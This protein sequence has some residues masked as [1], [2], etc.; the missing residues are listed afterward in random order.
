MPITRSGSSQPDPAS[1]LGDNREEAE[2]PLEYFPET[3]KLAAG[4]QFSHRVPKSGMVTPSCCEYLEGI[5]S[6]VAKLHNS[7]LV[8]TIEA[9]ELE[10]ELKRLELRERQLALRKRQ[11]KISGHMGEAEGVAM[12]TPSNVD[13]ATHAQL[14]THELPEVEPR[15]KP[16]KKVRLPELEL[17]KF[18]GEPS[19]LWR[20]LRTFKIDVAEHLS[21]DKER[22]SYLIHCCTG[23]AREAIEDCKLLLGVSGYAR[24]LKI[25]EMQFGC[26]DDVAEGLLEELVH[27]NRLKAG[28]VVGLRKLLRQATNCEISL[29]ELGYQASLNCS[30]IIKSVVR[31]LPEHLQ[32]KWA[33]QV[34][35]KRI[36]GVDL[37][38]RDLVAFL[39]RGLS[40]ST[41]CHG[42][43]SKETPSQSGH[44]NVLV[45]GTRSR[46]NSVVT[47]EQIGCPICQVKHRLE[48][49]R[50]FQDMIHE[51]RLSLLRRERR[52][53]KCLQPGHVAS[54][55]YT[56]VHCEEVGCGRRH[57]T[58]LHF[59]RTKS[60]SASI[61]VNSTKTA[62]SSYM[63]FVPVRIVGPTGIMETYAFLDSGSDTTL[64]SS[65][66]ATKVGISGP[67]TSIAISS[68]QGTTIKRSN[69]VKFLIRPLQ[70]E[71][72][73]RID[74]AYVVERLPVAR[75]SVPSEETVCQWPHLKSVR[76]SRIRNDKVGVLLGTN[77]PEVHWVQKQTIGTKTQ[78]YASLTVLGWVLFGPSSES[79]DRP[80]AVNCIETDDSIRSCV[81]KMFELDFADTRDDER[82]NLSVEDAKVL[83]LVRGSSKLYEGH[84]QLPLP[85]RFDWRKLPENRVLA[86][87]RLRYLMFRLQ[88]DSELSGQYD[89]IIR[90]YE[91]KGYISQL[92]SS[93]RQELR[94]LPHHPVINPRKPGKVRIVFDFAA[95]FKGMSIN[96]CLY[97]GP[98]LTNEL[99]SVLLR[100]RLGKIALAADIEE[101]F[102]Q[103]RLRLE[104]KPPLCFL[105]YPNGQL[106]ESP[107]VYQLNV[108]PFGATSSPFIA[109][110]AL[111]Q[112]VEDNREHFDEY[113]ASV[114]EENFYVDDCLTSVDTITTAI[115]LVEQLRC[116]LSRGGFRLH[117]WVSNSNEVMN[118]IPASERAEDLVNVCPS[119]STMQKTLG[120]YW[121]VQRDCFRFKVSLPS[122]PATR[123]GIL[124][125]SASL[126]DP[127]GFVAPVLLQPKR[128]LQNMCRLGCGWDEE[129]DTQVEAAWTKWLHDVR[130]VENLRIPRCINP[131]PSPTTQA[132]LHLFSD[133][134]EIG[135]GAVAYLRH[136]TEGSTAHVSFLMG[137]SRVAPLKAITIPR[138]ELQAA[139]LSVKLWS[140]VRRSLKI[141]V[142]RARFWTDSTI[143]LHY[144][145]NTRSRFKTFVANRI[146]VILKNTYPEQWG[147][148]HTDEN[149]ADLAS[150][151][152][153]REVI[154]NLERWLH[155]P[156]FL[157]Q[158]EGSWPRRFGESLKCDFSQLEIKKESTV[159]GITTSFDAVDV[160]ISYY[161]SWSKLLR[162]VAWLL[163]FK[164]YLRWNM[165]K[166]P[167]LAPAAGQLSCQ[168]LDSAELSVLRYVQS[169]S[170]GMT[171]PKASE[172]DTCKS[173]NVDKNCSVRK[174]SPVLVKGLICVGGRLNQSNISD[175]AKNPVILPSNHA[176]TECI[177]NYYHRT[178][179]HAGMTH[180]LATLRQKYWIIRGAATVRRVLRRCIGCKQRTAKPIEQLMSGLPAA[181]L[182]PDY[183][184]AVTG[185]D[186]FG[187]F[188]VREGRSNRKRYG[189]LFTCLKT[190]A[191]HI[192]V[193]HELTVDS[194]LMALYRFIG[195]RGYPKEIFSDQG[196]NFVGAEMELRKLVKSFEVERI[197][198]K[199]LDKR[200][201]WHFHPPYASHRGGIWERLIRSI[202]RILSA[203]SREQIGTTETLTT[204]LV[205]VERILNARP[206]IPVYDDPDC[207]GVLT[208]RDLL[209][210]RQE[211]KVMDADIDLRERYTRQWRQS[212]TLTETFWRRWIKE[213]LPTLQNRNKWHKSRRNLQV[214]DLV[215]II[216]R[217]VARGKWPKGVV[218]GI[219]EGNDMRV[220]E[221][222]IRTSNGVVRRDVRK[223]CLLEGVSED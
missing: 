61:K 132:E 191:V 89:Q 46:I 125:C 7:E 151:G 86:E 123:R 54:K 39:E 84:Y 184:F 16:P 27:G 145:H 81:L 153:D 57:H 38:F 114:V 212:Q 104:D 41:Y 105:W 121:C 163:R 65:E 21:N 213:Y 193:A 50:R 223:L 149:P 19:R 124:S 221:A 127:L 75:A 172:T 148:I 164:R 166:Q 190:R 207:P 200:I 195:R 58:L 73:V 83:E 87:K 79:N 204:Y 32:I 222:L 24:A 135:Y 189:C 11:L 91:K 26:S 182:V 23:E 6:D 197:A 99:T 97:S 22:L 3:S 211:T 69:S 185:V 85:W 63:G 53:F 219:T 159:S 95:K 111:K 13:H 201:D 198:D 158:P 144:I 60:P 56:D 40:L 129:V 117:K 168:D 215:L 217:R 210:M 110:F 178:E 194:F 143:V 9:E 30:T 186:Y 119:D 78:P 170:F 181:R 96:D 183:P 136:E 106:R 112:T 82:Q 126:Y 45:T 113:T 1:V 8:E 134:S 98:D 187:P 92:V 199:L 138:L 47:N 29:S 31:R 34:L 74:Q 49:C 179:G 188:F 44:K 67:T 142:N 4:E 72:D 130:M 70:A 18:D 88:R 122:K 133:A 140:H 100:F 206:L 214:G 147:H 137:K 150:R 103:V 12:R 71:Y 62:R 171:P 93:E 162:S 76:L 208:P 20:F 33:D 94:F 220:R 173:L 169:V 90:S 152:I 108:H 2:V 35:D 218:S 17:P 77:V 177:I 141:P 102:L 167:E 157:T 165:N 176:V 25:L 68:F 51:D 115:R 161:S 131:L 14:S 192:E 180:V 48:S 154:T 36:D 42:Q 209:L 59:N 43:G 120:L 216:D 109:N 64:L 80:L 37:T 5:E 15:H 101:M 174:L 118:T 52:C 66:V 28:D 156:Q 175:S 107:Q 155:G 128:L 10:I 196:T 202:R 203:V 139:V 116:L 160:F 205:E 55:C 146:G